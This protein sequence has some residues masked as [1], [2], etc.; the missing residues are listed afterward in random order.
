MFHEDLHLTHRRQEQSG[1]NSSKLKFP[2]VLSEGFPLSC[3]VYNI[4]VLLTCPMMFA[5]VT[6]LQDAWKRLKLLKAASLSLS[7]CASMG[8]TSAVYARK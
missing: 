2:P 1:S 3:Q 8:V 6:F 5:A 7:I 4:V